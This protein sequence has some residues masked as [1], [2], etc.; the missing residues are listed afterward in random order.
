MTMKGALRMLLVSL[1]LRQLMM[2]TPTCRRQLAQWHHFAKQIQ[3]PSKLKLRVKGKVRGL[4][5]LTNARQSLSEFWSCC[6]WPCQRPR[7][8]S[9][10]R[11]NKLWQIDLHATAMKA[12]RLF[13]PCR[14]ATLV[15]KRV[16][17]S[18]LTTLYLLVRLQLRECVST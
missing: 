11:F 1:H 4:L 5:S 14:F 17:P 3:M 13:L 12:E 7:T 15:S 18:S 16:C 10:P 9:G 8:S 6:K 2:M